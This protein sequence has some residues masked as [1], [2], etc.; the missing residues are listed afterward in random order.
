[1]TLSLFSVIT[2]SS[3]TIILIL[4]FLITA[5]ALVISERKSREFKQIN[6][7]LQSLINNVPDLIWVKDEKSRFI[8]VNDQFSKTFPFSK[9]ELI[10]KTDFDLNEDKILAQSYREDDLRVQQQMQ[11]LH[12]EEQIVGA[13]GNEGWAETIKVALVN[14]QG[15]VIGTAGMARNITKR[16]EAEQKMA[17]LVYHDELTGLPNRSGFT[18]QVNKLLTL[19]NHTVAV[20][21]FDL[22][23]FKHINDSLGHDSGDQTLKQIAARL[24]ILVDDNT[25]VARLSADEFVVAHNYAKLDNSLADLKIT[26]LEQFETPVVLNDIKHSI[27]ASFGVAIAPNDGQDCERL[28]QN[29]DLAMYQCRVS[30]S[31][32]YVH[33][34]PEF[35]DDLLYKMQLSNML[36]QGIVKKQFSLMY[37]PKVD[38][39]NSKVIGIEAL[40][41]W[42]IDEDKYISPYDFIPIAEKNGFIIE[43]GNWVIS[44][45]LQQMRTWIDNNIEITPVAINVSAIQLHQP[46]FAEHLLNQLAHYQIPAYLLQIELTESVLMG[47]ME[48]TIPQ[49]KKIRKKGVLVSID[50][51]GTG[52]SNLSYLPNLPVD[53]LKIDRVFISVL[54]QNLDNQK[55]VQTIVSLANNFNLTVIA[56]GVETL[57]EL[58]ATNKCG[59]VDIQGYYYSKP[60]LVSELEQNWLATIP[61]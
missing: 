13:D 51:F 18:Q 12:V 36:G 4:L 11:P 61:M 16:K 49:L 6:E 53:I 43:L 37:Q 55:I 29:A 19:N 42:K 34:M 31:K 21:L 17:H 22:N 59:V 32:S 14:K 33:F 54:N 44:T 10:G 46:D 48:G 47:N 20:I 40:L 24:K 52:Y 2:M 58:Q 41:R 60:L 23:N 50:D 9:E 8:F 25:I 57:E 15:K 35:A 56:E 3:I 28:L 38:S 39:S 26:L 5:L 27:S 1:M 7:H 45:V 30:H